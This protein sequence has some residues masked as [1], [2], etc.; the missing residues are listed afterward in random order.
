MGG[1]DSSTEL[2]RRGRVVEEEERELELYQR[3]EG[4]PPPL[5][6]SF[7][8]FSS[9][10]ISLSVFPSPNFTTTLS[11]LSV[12]FYPYY[13]SSDG[14]SSPVRCELSRALRGT[15][16]VGGGRGGV[17]KVKSGSRPKKEEGGRGERTFFV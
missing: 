12:L 15:K 8:F 10:L 2:E 4:S 5:S 13:Y 17:G 1:E 3:V 14:S 16:L 11:S 7:F 9:P 6:A